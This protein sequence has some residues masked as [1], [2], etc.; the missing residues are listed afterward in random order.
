MKTQQLQKYFAGKF[1]TK[2]IE[3]IEKEKKFKTLFQLKYR[4]NLFSKYYTI[5][6]IFLK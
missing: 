6:Q 5:L 1:E 4:R 2:T 3:I